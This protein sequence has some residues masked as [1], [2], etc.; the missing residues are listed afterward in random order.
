[1]KIVS[2][3]EVGRA[4]RLKNRSHLILELL[5]VINMARRKFIK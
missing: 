4:R 2:Q 5:Y 1:M 3:I